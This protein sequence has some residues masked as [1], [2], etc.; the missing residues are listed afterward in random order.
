[1][2]DWIN[3]RQ[4]KYVGNTVIEVNESEALCLMIGKNDHVHCL[5]YVDV[6]KNEQ[7]CKY[8]IW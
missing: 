1:M 7:L 5:V 3:W 4:L 2:Y 8:G 6:P